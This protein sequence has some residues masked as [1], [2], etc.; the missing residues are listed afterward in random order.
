[1]FTRLADSLIFSLTPK[2]M[3]FHTRVRLG[4]QKLAREQE[5]R[6]QKQQIDGNS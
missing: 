5:E 6:L 3:F 4:I 1:M 2:Y